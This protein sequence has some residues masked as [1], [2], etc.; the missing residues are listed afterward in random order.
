MF[1]ALFLGKYEDTIL[2]HLCNCYS[3][4]FSLIVFFCSKLAHK[5][6]VQLYGIC[7]LRPNICIVTEYMQKGS[8]GQIIHG[9]DSFNGNKKTL[10]WETRIKW[11]WSYSLCFL[12][13]INRVQ[14]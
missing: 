3:A 10:D 6:I 1:A 11:V 8:V 5:N 13:V 12:S 2:S 14:P 7:N 9:C 4:L